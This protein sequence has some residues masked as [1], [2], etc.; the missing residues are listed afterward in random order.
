M[1]IDLRKSK[2]DKVIYEKCM[3]CSNVKGNVTTINV[4]VNI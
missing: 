3:S 2:F 4:N 1:N